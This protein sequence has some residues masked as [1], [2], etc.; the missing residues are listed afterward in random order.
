M[1]GE[2]FIAIGIATDLA[3]SLPPV[4][5]E[6]PN[7]FT[8]VPFVGSCLP[9]FRISTGVWRTRR[10]KILNDVTCVLIAA[11]NPMRCP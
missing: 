3:M 7:H 11:Q 5:S 9:Q 8:V 2:L 10:A 4:A 6:S 1:N